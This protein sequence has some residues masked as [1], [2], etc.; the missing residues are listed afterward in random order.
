MPKIHQVAIA[1]VQKMQKSGDSVTATLSLPPRYRLPVA[2]GGATA[3]GNGFR[4]SF[5]SRFAV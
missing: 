3:F 5:S 4:G 1:D 2:R